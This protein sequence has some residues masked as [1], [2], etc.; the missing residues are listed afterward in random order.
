MNI[1]VQTCP[2][3]WSSQSSTISFP[4]HD[5][6]LRSVSNSSFWMPSRTLLAII[7]ERHMKTQKPQTTHNIQTGLRSIRFHSKHDVIF[8]VL[9]ESS[10]HDNSVPS[11]SIRHSPLLNSRLNFE[12]RWHYVHKRS[13]YAVLPRDEWTSSRLKRSTEKSNRLFSLSCRKCLWIHPN[14]KAKR[15]LYGYYNRWCSST[16]HILMVKMQ[17]FQWRGWAALSAIHS[18]HYRC[19]HPTHGTEGSSW[20]ERQGSLDKSLVVHPPWMVNILRTWRPSVAVVAV[21]QEVP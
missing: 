9:S 2:T 19:S 17:R 13:Q 4:F 11:C 18:A 12:L 1:P 15:H 8:A 6:S 16:P 5:V 7:I 10:V 21:P 20:T 3:T 14:F